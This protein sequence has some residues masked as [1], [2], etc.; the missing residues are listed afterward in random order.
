MEILIKTVNQLG[1]A[2]RARRTQLKL[3]Q[4]KTGS[5]VGLLAKTISALELNPERSSIS[6]LLKLLSALDLELVLRP[7]DSSSEK[8]DK[9]EW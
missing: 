9:L 4:K 7:K 1:Q 8:T 2:V 5:T 3:T 6:S